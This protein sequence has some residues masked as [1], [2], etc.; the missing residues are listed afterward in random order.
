MKKLLVLGLTATIL[1][2]A[3]IGCSGSKVQTSDNTKPAAATAP[4]SS[5]KPYVAVVAKGFQSQY[6]QVVKKGADDAASKLGAKITFDGPDS[7]SNIQQQVDMINS[8]IAKKPKALAL[9]VLDTKSVTS[10]LQ[11]CK[12]GSIPVIGFDSGVPGDASGALKATAATNNAKAAAIAADNM[13]Q[14]S[15]FQAAVQKGTE[16]SPV[17]VGVLSQDATSASITQRTSGFIDELVAKLES[18]NGFAGAVKVQGQTNFN[19]DSKNAPKVIIQVNVP[20]STSAT[21]LQNGAQALLGTKNLIAVFGSNQTAADGILAA[22][23]DGSDL[24]RNTGKYKNII[25]AGFDAGKGQKAAVKNGWFIGSVTQDP[26]TI[27]YQAVSL[28]LDAI[29]G[30]SVSDTDTGAK[31]YNAKNMNDASIAQLLYD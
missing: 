30:K 15:N 9:A 11:N 27:G 29:N 6:W 17:V 12:S 2:T 8:A 26:Y 31:W 28:A 13:F 5:D 14:D 21:D 16:A 19:K 7:E 25:A 3:L 4:A 20:P 23:N 10:Q 18:L 24:D 1:A 22:T